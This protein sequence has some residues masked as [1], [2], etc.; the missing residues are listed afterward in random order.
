[1]LLYDGTAVSGRMDRR[2]QAAGAA[3]KAAAILIDA[4]TRR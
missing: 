3:R 2:A 1:V 4:A